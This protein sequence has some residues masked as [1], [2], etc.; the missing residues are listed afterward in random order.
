MKSQNKNIPRHFSCNIRVAENLCSITPLIGRNWL[1][2]R[3]ISIT[4]HLQKTQLNSVCWKYVVDSL[5]STYKNVV[6]SPEWV[7][8]NC[9]R[10]NFTQKSTHITERNWTHK[11]IY[12]NPPKTII[13]T[14]RQIGRE[15]ERKREREGGREGERERERERE[16][17]GGKKHTIE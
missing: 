3:G 5:K 9:L 10:T 15:G 12:T 6:A 7:L 8:E 17:E 11:K 2:G 16:R 1:S 4:H 13:H 14:Q